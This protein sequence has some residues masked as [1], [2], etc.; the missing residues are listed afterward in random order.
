MPLMIALQVFEKRI[1]GAIRERISYPRIGLVEPITLAEAGMHRGRR[2]IMSSFVLFKLRVIGGSLLIAFGSI[3]I[4]DPMM[5]PNYG[6]PAVFALP[7]GAVS[8]HEGLRP[9]AG[10]RVRG[11]RSL[12]GLDRIIH[13]LAATLYVVGKAAFLYLHGRP[14]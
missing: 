2:V 7:M 12:N 9:P 11:H 10:E 13:E 14:S 8:I 3:R 6:I 1:L 5:M 4:P